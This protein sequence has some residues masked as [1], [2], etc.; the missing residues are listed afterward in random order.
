MF[1]EFTVE[2]ES[3]VDLPLLSVNCCF[4]VKRL[5]RG[6]P[7]FFLPVV[8]LKSVPLKMATNY[9]R[10]AAAKTASEIKLET[11][12]IRLD[13]VI[14]CEK[15]GDAIKM[16]PPEKEIEKKCDIPNTSGCFELHWNNGG[17]GY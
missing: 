3:A 15:E 8:G 5:A 4:I 1:L 9:A 16:I 17:R 11:V 12:N 2:S 14:R 7:L 10:V 13:K 6:A